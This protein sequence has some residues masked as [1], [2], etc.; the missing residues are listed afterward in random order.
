MRV[1]MAEVKTESDPSLNLLSPRLRVALMVHGITVGNTRRY[2]PSCH[3]YPVN[4]PE[5]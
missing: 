3:L 5:K 2:G 4:F 1:S